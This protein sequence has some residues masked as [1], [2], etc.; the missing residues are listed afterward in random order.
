M[1]NYSGRFSVSKKMLWL[2]IVVIAAFAVGCTDKTGAIE[3]PLPPYSYITPTVQNLKTYA[4][5]ISK[6]SG[7]ILRLTSQWASP[8]PVSTATAYI[9]FV[10]TIQNPKT[11][12]IGII[13]SA[14]ATL[15]RDLRA[16]LAWQ[17]T[18][19]ATSPCV[20]SDTEAFYRMF[21]EPVQIPVRIGTDENAGLFGAE[22]P[23]AHQDIASAPLGVHQMMFYMYI[24][25]QKT[26]TL[27]FE[28]TFVP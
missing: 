4:T 18:T 27:S 2:F 16:G 10:R 21:A 6:C 20:A 5:S 11:E 3:D 24:N 22:I 26:N 7:G 9:G 15:S 19:I 23:F 28:L 1:K 14:V 17:T 8:Y 25:R 13:A 12:P